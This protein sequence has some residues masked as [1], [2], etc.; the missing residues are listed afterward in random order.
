VPFD[1]VRV[2]VASVDHAVDVGD[3][4]RLAALVQRASPWAAD[5]YD[6]A[7]AQARAYRALGWTAA[8]EGALARAD[9]LSGSSQSR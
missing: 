8:W 5:S 9:K 6:A 3:S 2:V 7:L 4:S 1:V